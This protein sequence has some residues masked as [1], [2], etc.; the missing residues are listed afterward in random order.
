MLD[1]RAGR[2]PCRAGEPLKVLRAARDEAIATLLAL[3]G[4][5]AARFLGIVLSDTSTSSCTT[6][7]DQS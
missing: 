3:D 7:N 2:A 5:A 1:G 4:G 6:A